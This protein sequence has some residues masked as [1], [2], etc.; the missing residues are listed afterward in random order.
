[1][2]L[3]TAVSG[4]QSPDSLH[5]SVLMEEASAYL[6]TDRDGSYVDATY[7]RG[8]HAQAILRSLSMQSGLLV[9][10]KDADAIAHARDHVGQDK[11]VSVVH[12]SF[13]NL[14]A[15]LNQAVTGVLFDLGVSSPQF[16]QAERGFSFNK[17]GPLDMRMDQSRGITALAWLKASSEQEIADTL[18]QYGEERH[19]RK[20]AGRIKQALSENRL[21][22]TIHL[23]EL[24]VGC[25]GRRP[26]R[27]HPATRT[28]QALRIRVNNELTDLESV[29]ADVVQVLVPGGRMVVISFHSLEDRIVKYFIKGQKHLKLLA[30]V[31]PGR[32]ECF[33]NRRAR[34]AL[35]RVAEVVQSDSG[36]MVK[37]KDR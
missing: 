16:D 27:K 23:A 2:V 8:G 1:M 18:W 37:M 31:K 13:V 26:G 10:D 17:D 25:I 15:H 11:R 30:K 32:A 28:F 33:S 29:L 9:M 3:S 35:M 4:T 22:T 34:S 6:I 24:V 21:T 20:I 5:E 12:D 14:T 19:S 7:G 36:C